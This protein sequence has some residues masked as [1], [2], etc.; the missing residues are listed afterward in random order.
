MKRF[1]NLVAIV[2]V[3]MLLCVACGEK[4]IVETVEKMYAEGTERLQKAR[5]YEDIQNLYDDVEVQV[6]KYQSEHTEEFASL[7]STAHTLQKTKEDF[8]KACCNS[9]LFYE[10]P[11]FYLRT[12]NGFACVGKDGNVEYSIDDEGEEWEGDNSNVNNPLGVTGLTPVYGQNYY[13]S[14]A[15][16]NYFWECKYVTVQNSKGDYLYSDE[17]AERYYEGYLNLFFMARRI[18][19]GCRNDENMREYMKNNLSNI[20]THLP[21]DE[22]YPE[23]IREYA[24][25]IYYDWKDAMSTLHISKRGYGYVKCTY[26]VNGDQNNRGSFYLRRDEENGRLRF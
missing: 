8:L 14:G 15:G 12:E 6:K 23:N 26:Y 19:D 17:D 2:M 10:G 1:L 22:S 5:T 13:E 4:N 18:A 24:N 20:V 3:T 25:K 16:K 9:L 7:D 11:G 21:L